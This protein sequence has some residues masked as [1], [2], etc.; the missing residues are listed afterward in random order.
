VLHILLNNATTGCR[1]LKIFTK[2]CR[3][4]KLFAKHLKVE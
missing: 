4:V 2:E 1:D 3:R